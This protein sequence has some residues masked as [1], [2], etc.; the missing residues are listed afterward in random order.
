ML[1]FHI[2]K[3]QIILGP[4]VFYGNIH[5]HYSCTRILCHDCRLYVLYL[6]LSSKHFN[7]TGFISQI[8][9]FAALMVISGKAQLIGRNSFFPLIKANDLYSIENNS[10]RPQKN[11]KKMEFGNGQEKKNGLYVYSQMT[12]S[13]F[14]NVLFYELYS[15]ASWSGEKETWFLRQFPRSV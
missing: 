7:I 15:G 6:P 9:F 5:G 10:L 12:C 8:T 3:K 1:V 11:Q 13:I 4:V 2:P 14:R